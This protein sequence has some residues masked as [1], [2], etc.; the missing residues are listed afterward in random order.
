MGL[1]GVSDLKTGDNDRDTPLHL[2]E[3][4]ECAQ[5]LLEAGADLNARNSD[6][7]TVG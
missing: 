3:T 5:V 6:G 2:C 1:T 4:V 7:R